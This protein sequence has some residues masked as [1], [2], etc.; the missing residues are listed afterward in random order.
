MGLLACHGAAH[1]FIAAGQTLEIGHDVKSQ[2]RESGHGVKAPA[3]F[4]L[5]RLTFAD[6]LRH[7]VRNVAGGAAHGPGQLAIAGAAGG[8]AA[9]S[10]KQ[11]EHAGRLV[12]GFRQGGHDAIPARAAA[13]AALVRRKTGRLLMRDQRIDAVTG[14]FGNVPLDKGQFTAATDDLT[15]G[16]VGHAQLISQS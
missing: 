14:D 11:I 13:T 8:V 3:V 1:V 4:V 12:A 10:F 9:Q 15:H 2:A 5:A 16:T 6:E 7:V